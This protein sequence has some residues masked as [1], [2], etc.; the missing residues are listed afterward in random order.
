MRATSWQ[1]GTRERVMKYKQ[2]KIQE[3][4]I[5]NN[6][7]QYPLSLR[8]YDGERPVR[9]DYSRTQ[10]TG[11]VRNDLALGIHFEDGIL[12]FGEEN[13]RVGVREGV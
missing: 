6:V 7:Q 10:P 4:G 11:L 2:T 8:R 5:Y 12:G 3:Q 1:L 9:R 13:E